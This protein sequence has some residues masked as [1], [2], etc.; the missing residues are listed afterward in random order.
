MQLP[1]MN[2]NSLKDVL[3]FPLGIKERCNGKLG[4]PVFSCQKAPTFPAKTG[5]LGSHFQSTERTRCHCGPIIRLTI[6][7]FQSYINMSFHKYCL[8]VMIYSIPSTYFGGVP[9]FK[10][11]SKCKIEQYFSWETGKQHKSRKTIRFDL[12]L[13]NDVLVEN[14]WL[15]NFGPKARRVL[16]L[17]AVGIF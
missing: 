3:P 6:N 2:Q 11:W 9:E 12:D 13:I 5:Y 7:R 15:D 4:P 16:I 10:I 8:V 17:E 1:F 14:L